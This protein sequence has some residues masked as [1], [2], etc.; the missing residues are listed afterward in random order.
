MQSV[1]VSESK[2][3]LKRIA[4]GVPQGSL[5]GPLLFL[6]FV[7]NLS[8]AITYADAN[9]FADDTMLFHNHSSLKSLTKIV[10][11]DL[12]LLTQR[13]NGNKIA[14]NCIKTELLIFKPKRRTL[15]HDIKIKISGHR[16]HP[17]KL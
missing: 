12:N 15:D 7:N 6:I 14:L 3:K 8:N 5:L 9:L 4:H 1:T 13:L 10:N 11:I 16:L 2:S 17:V